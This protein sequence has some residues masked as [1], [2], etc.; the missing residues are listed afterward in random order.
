MTHSYF[1]GKTECMRAETQTRQIGHVPRSGILLVSGAHIRQDFRRSPPLCLFRSQSGVLFPCRAISS[2]SKSV[3]RS[4]EVRLSTGKFNRLI[5]LECVHGCRVRVV[6]CASCAPQDH[7]R[8]VPRTAWALP[9]GGST[10]ADGNFLSKLCCRFLC[11]ACSVSR[12][13]Q[14]ASRD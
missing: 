5:F 12:R 9:A 1:R 8:R 7:A 11:F 10:R 6:S 2:S 4:P 3:Q 14:R 13:R